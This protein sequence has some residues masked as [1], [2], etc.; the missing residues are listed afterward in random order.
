M[1]RRAREFQHGGPVWL[2]DGIWWVGHVLKDDPF[3]CHAYLIEHG[4]QCV[5]I[6]PGSAL[7]WGHVR[8]QVEHITPLSNVRYLVAS[9]QDADITAAIPFIEQESDR[10][11]LQI[12]THWRTQTII[13]HLGLRSDIYRVEDHAWTLDL[14]GRV[15]RFVLTPYAH[16]PGAFVTFDTRTGVLFTSDLFG[17]FTDGQRLFAD[18]VDDFEVLRP[19]HQHYMPSREVLAYAMAQIESLPVTLIA[20]QHGLLIDEELIQPMVQQLA[21]L[22]CGLYLIAGGDTQIERLSRVNSLMHAINRALAVTR[23]FAQICRTLREVVHDDVPIAKWTFCQVDANGEVENLAEDGSPVDDMQPLP[24]RA[25]EFLGFDERQ[26]MDHHTQDFVYFPPGE[27]YSDGRAALV[28][29]LFDPDRRVASTIACAALDHEDFSPTFLS[30][31]G[32]YIT[33]PLQVAL[34]REIAR[35][36]TEADKR[37]FYQQAIRDPLTGLFTRVYMEDAV[38]RLVQLHD[39]DPRAHLA[40]AMF[41]IDHF[42]SVN[43]TWG[44]NQGDTVLRRVAHTLLDN[45]RDSDLPIRFGGEEF[46]VFLT[47]QPGDSGLVVPE[48]VRRE[49]SSLTFDEP[50]HERTITLSAGYAV[51]RQGESRVDLIERADTALYRAKTNGRDQVCVAD[52]SPPRE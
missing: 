44:H 10:E 52:E 9:H 40:L 26:W 36:R 1:D 2:A 27:G 33:A 12:V 7:T 23:D 3:Q 28:L 51:H 50:M 20:P 30:E 16:F 13:R 4:D 5:L 22:D 39:R 8:A 43:D 48:R 45:V 29:P 41:D 18:S 15:L 49:V 31:I 34:E 42:K 47:G 46:A 35:R 11:D 37:H 32:A 6:D 17:G 24:L 38:Q 19:F 21:E 25:D 14:G